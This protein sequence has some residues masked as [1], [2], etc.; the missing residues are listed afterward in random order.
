MPE[1]DGSCELAGEAHLACLV[2]R[3][4][5]R[6]VGSGVAIPLTPER[7]PVRIEL[8][9]ENVA[10]PRALQRT[11]AEIEGVHEIADEQHVVHAIHS[12]PPG[13]LIPRA[14]DPL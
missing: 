12:N 9:K 7:V 2:D 8:G 3:N 5:A 13:M 11:P 6:H 10:C 4:T 1:I 14:A